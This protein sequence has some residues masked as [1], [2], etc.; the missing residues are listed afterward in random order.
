MRSLELAM[1]RTRD[2]SFGEEGEVWRAS[3]VMA[4]WAFTQSSDLL[5]AMFLEPEVGVGLI[6]HCDTGECGGG[7]IDVGRTGKG[8]EQD[9]N[10]REQHKEGRLP[11]GML[12]G[13]DE[14]LEVNLD[15]FWKL[16]H[17]MERGIAWE[18]VLSRRKNVSGFCGWGGLTFAFR[19]VYFPS[20]L[21]PH[22][23][24]VL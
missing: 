6:G 24:T 9:S 8:E 19:S 11:H 7:G 16:I 12:R 22:S 23:L 10:D 15:L 5:A 14:G 2:L 3:W 20:V 1:A 17:F 21:S 4:F 13:F 18:R